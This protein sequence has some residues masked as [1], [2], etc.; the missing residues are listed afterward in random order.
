MSS[1]EREERLAKNEVVFR[2]LNENIDEAASQFGGQDHLYEF[3]CECSTRECFELLSL[4]LQEYEHVRA[5][6]ARFV[7]AA[8]H[9]DI[10]VELVVEVHEGFI[11][12]EK[13]GTAGIV[14]HDDN[15]RA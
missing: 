2:A 13:Y 6:G 1:E 5:D 10:E 15:P 4:T 14:A 3:I 8:G 12:V 11:I 9:E 7:L